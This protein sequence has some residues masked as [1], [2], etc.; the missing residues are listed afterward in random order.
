MFKRSTD[1]KSREYCVE[2]RKKKEK[3]IMYDVKRNR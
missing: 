3:Y 2:I 1:Y